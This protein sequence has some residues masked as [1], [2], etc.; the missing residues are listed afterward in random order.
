[1]LAFAAILAVPNLAVVL[2]AQVLFGAAIGLMYYSSLFYAMDAS[3][4]KSEHGGIHEAAIG[5][6]NCLGPAAGAAALWLAPNNPSMDVW[7]V[8]SLLTIGLGG[9]IWVQKKS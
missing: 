1:M 6:G 8:S 4:T 9:L 2:V 5:I 3:D 7:A